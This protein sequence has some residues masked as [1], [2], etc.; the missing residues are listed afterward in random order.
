MAA[1]MKIRM[2]LVGS[3]AFEYA[4]TLF[5]NKCPTC[6]TVLTEERAF[7]VSEDTVL[8]KTPEDPDGTELPRVKIDFGWV[9]RPAETGSYQWREAVKSYVAELQAEAPSGVKVDAAPDSE[10]PATAP[11]QPMVAPP[12]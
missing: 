5:G 10:Q 4:Q 7:F 12:Q 8:V 3:K 2:Y 6:H 1:L 9:L 11:Q